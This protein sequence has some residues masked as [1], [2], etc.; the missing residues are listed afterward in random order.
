[1]VAPVVAAS[2]V[3][4][5]A[6]ILGGLI[7]S[8]GQTS[9]NQANL[10]LARENRAWQQMMS[11]TAYQRSAGDLK[12]AGLNRIL[13]LGSPGSTPSG[14]VATMQNEKTQL[15]AGVSAAAH[16]AATLAQTAAQIKL[17]NAQTTK[18]Q[19]ETS[20]LDT[21][22]PYIHTQAELTFRQAELTRLK[23][24]AAQ[25]EPERLR[26]QLTQMGI[27][28]EQA[29]MLL[30]LYRDNPKLMLSQQFDWKGA[31]TAV[32][33]IGAGMFAGGK[34]IKKLYTVAKKA[35]WLGTLGQFTTKFGGGAIR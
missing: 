24:V 18:V 15:G 27:S 5:G 11:N 16:S 3:G 23:S 17:V 4:A 10:R 22:R 20:T 21:Q 35:G 25:L 13:A 19:S 6:N 34:A 28:N 33:G 29:H 32:A 30:K 8:R 26:R 12:A 7:G 1:M 14:N 9:A 31:L 2:L